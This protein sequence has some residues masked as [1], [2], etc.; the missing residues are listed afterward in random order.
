MALLLAQATGAWAQ[1]PER[2]DLTESGNGTVWTL[3]DGMPDYDVDIEVVFYTDEEI[4]EME[5]IA[6]FTEGVELMQGGQNEWTLAA[7]PH[8]DID[9]AMEY[10]TALAL[11]EVEDNTEKLAEWN[12]YEADVTLTRTLQAGGWNT[13]AVPFGIGTDDLA[14]LQ[15]MLALQDGSIEVKKFDGSTLVGETLTLNFSDATAMEAGTPYL[16]KVSK[17]LDFA[18][19][20]AQ[21][22]ALNALGNPFHDAVISRQPVV[23]ETDYADFIPTLGK[24]TIENVA[25]E[26]VLFVAAENKL[27]NPDKM[28]TDMKG[29]R[30]YF[31]LKNLPVAA[32][33]FSLN[34]GDGMTTSSGEVPRVKSGEAAPAA[35]WYDLQ[36]RKVDGQ[37]QKGLYIKH[38]SERRL[39]GKNGKKLVIK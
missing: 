3:P 36:G 30:A 12:G 23:V 7:T 33:S 13:L 38:S 35:E 11:N 18:T 9:M 29:F 1:T 4:A 6:V 37:L 32:R 10:E 26:D 25:A 39:H 5:E 27:K 20:P 8:F 21:M 15:E 28:P 14:A 31:Q 34:F 19:L 2:I 22:E 16:V 24:T 17:A